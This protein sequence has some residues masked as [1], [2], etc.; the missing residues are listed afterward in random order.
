MLIKTVQNTLAVVAVV[1]PLVCAGGQSKTC[2]T[3]AT[4]TKIEVEWP[5]TPAYE[6]D[7]WLYWYVFHLTC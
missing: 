1:L 5:S 7:Q 6:S 4:T 3:I 2:T